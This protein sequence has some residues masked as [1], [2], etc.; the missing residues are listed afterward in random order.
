MSPPLSPS[1]PPSPLAEREV[2]LKLSV[3]GGLA[4]KQR[5]VNTSGGSASAKEGQGSVKVKGPGIRATGTEELRERTR[6]HALMEMDEGI[7]IPERTLG[8]I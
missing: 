2:G 5:N 1:Y 8:A 3:M 7:T 6:P 4:R